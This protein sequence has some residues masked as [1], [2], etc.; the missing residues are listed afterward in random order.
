ME[1]LGKVFKS[2]DMSLEIKAKIIYTLISPSTMC[3]CESQKVKE[4]DRKKMI[5]LNYGVGGKLHRYPEPP[6]RQANEP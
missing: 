1:K 2:Q 4:A 3:Q 5:H 6:E